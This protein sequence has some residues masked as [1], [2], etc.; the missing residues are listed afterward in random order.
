MVEVEECAAENLVRRP[1]WGEFRRHSVGNL[2]C[3]SCRGKV[4][5]RSTGD[6]KCKPCRR[7][8]DNYWETVLGF[9][10]CRFPPVHY[11]T[12]FQI[13]ILLLPGKRE[14]LRD[15]CWRWISL[16][17]MKCYCLET[18]VTRF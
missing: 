6:F 15:I 9:K 3:R 10:R 17:G 2:V 16:L 8:F 1:C 11:L 18:D 12:K 5:R 4:K 14:L 7:V 13:W